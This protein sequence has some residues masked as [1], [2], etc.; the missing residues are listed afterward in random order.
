M[1]CLI[2]VKAVARLEPARKEMKLET[3]ILVATDDGYD[4]KDELFVCS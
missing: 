1:G 4:E 3:L 2:D